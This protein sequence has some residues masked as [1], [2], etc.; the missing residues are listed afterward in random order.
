M[1]KVLHRGFKPAKCKT[2]LQMANSR[3][4]ILKNKKEIQIKQLRR[5]LAQL[6]EAGHTPTARIRVSNLTL[7]FC[8][9]HSCLCLINTGECAYM[10]LSLSQV[11]H[12]VRE[13]KTVAAYELIG[14]Y[15]ELIVVRLGV[16]ESQKHCP[17]DLKEAVTSVL[18]ASQ[19][20]S[21]VPELSEIVK[22]FTTKY[23]KDFATSAI[24]LRPDSG[25]SRLLVEKLSAKPPDGPTKVKILMEIAAEHNVVWEAQ[26]FVEPDPKDQVL[27]G[28]S[29]FQSASSMNKEQ[30]PN[31]QAPST[32][33]VQHGSSERHHSPESSYHTSDG[34]SSSR[35][36]VV[37]SGKVEDYH[38]P[39]ARPSRSRA[40]EGECRNPNHGNENTS[41]RSNHRW[42]TEFADST[43]A[44][45]AAAEAAER[46]SFAARA[47]AELSSKERMTRQNSSESH[48]S[49]ASV[50]F[51]NE[52]SHR[53]NRSNVQSE[54]SSEDN[55]SPR[56]N[57]RMQHRTRQDSYGRAKE[58]EIPPVD[59]LSERHSLENSRKSGSFG[60][61]VRE[62]QPSEDER[63]LNVGYSEDVH[64]RKQSSRASSH[65]HSSNYSDENVIGSDYMK[66]PSVV[67]ENIFATE[68]DHQS[69]SSFK[70]T[71]SHGHGHDDAAAAD[72]FDDYGSFFD[73][74]KFDAEDEYDDHG[75]GFSLL[76]SKT[77]TFAPT[78]AASW[79]FK[80]DHS[81]SHVNHSSSLQV[82][83][84]S[85]NSPLF[86]DV[87]TSPPSSYHEPDPHAKFDNYDGPNSESD[88]D[89]PRHRGKVSGGLDER[90]NLTSDRSQ[91]FQVSDAVG[92]ELFTVDTEEHKDDSRTRE[93]S[94]SEAESQ[95]GLNFRPLVG[96][97][98]NKKTLPPY[99]IGLA[100][101]HN[102][103]DDVVR[104]MST[105]SSSRKDIYTKKAS[106]I[107][108]RPS[109]TPPHPSSSS[110]DDD[111]SEIQLRG[112]RTE[113][114][115]RSSYRHS[116]VSHDDSE[117]ELPK[118]ASVRS[119]VRT[120]KPTTGMRDH[121][122]PNFKAPA[123]SSYEDDE[124][125][126]E[127][128][129]ARVSATPTKTTGVSLRTKG[130]VKAH[131]KRSFP[132]T[133]TKTDKESRDQPSPRHE[134]VT[135][136][137]VK[138]PDP[139]TP[140]RERASH[141]HPNLPDY[142]DVFARL[143]ALRAPNRR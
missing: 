26:S 49:S 11:E 12:V 109:S 85:P 69:Q 42:E 133:A 132:V 116:H 84:E 90:V 15:C 135:S 61:T 130:Q 81:N 7:W 59:Q 141:V 9:H 41:S 119:Q 104:S 16:I 98:R 33:N 142:D 55:S 65:S 25:V 108:K 126:V 22:Q 28:A 129:I 19:R 122:R 66:S 20:L 37:S 14:I 36:N 139:E 56:G 138:S 123:S 58:S 34:R 118:R 72:T 120:G 74:P 39:N 99:R 77:P 35:S 112:R 6:L 46:A 23:G 134:T 117:E 87:S 92:H 68:Y 64:L 32:V 40:D 114:K 124:D 24:E 96:G 75:V 80:G 101:E 140:S 3:L 43:D 128:D 4:K 78:P 50:N 13:E 67:E 88:D 105:S 31:V 113:T 70:H 89:Q 100:R 83:Q 51:R 125:E 2:A 107:E 143:G 53:R 21:D 91:K 30:P 136:R 45:R 86:D 38:H 44:A 62:K 57:V 1:K 110:D 94:D 27:S 29:S 106:N 76:G 18:F 10:L 103:T 63:D 54:S 121:N 8:L 93:E 52:P 82:F 48:V 115:H 131:E 102:G 5:E 71:D 137:P 60:K 79:S 127:R 95:T 17:I 111:D 97:F 73:K 47:A